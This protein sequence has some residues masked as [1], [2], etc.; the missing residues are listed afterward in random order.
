MFIT[1]T[2]EICSESASVNESAQ[3]EVLVGLEPRD[4]Q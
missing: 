2:H 4:R 3:L 1:M